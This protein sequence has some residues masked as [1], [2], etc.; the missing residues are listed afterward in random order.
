LRLSQKIRFVN[1][2]RLLLA[3]FFILAGINHFIAPSI[4]LSIV[5]TY[6]PWPKTLVVISG[7]AEIIGGI[8][9][10]PARTQVW[11]GWGLIALLLVVFPANIQAIITGMIIAGHAVPTWLL[12][13]RLPFQLLLIVWVYRACVRPRKNGRTALGIT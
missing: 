1:A 8:G 10:L 3:A 4:Y 11:A 6:L 13:A 9:V 2:S 12:W 5:P 7:L